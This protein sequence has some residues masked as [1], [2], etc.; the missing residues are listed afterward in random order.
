MSNVIHIGEDGKDFDR[1]V[2]PD[3]CRVKC[4]MHTECGGFTYHHLRQLCRYKHHQPGKYDTSIQSKFVSCYVYKQPIPDDDDAIGVKPITAEEVEEALG[5]GFLAIFVIVAVLIVLAGAAATVL[6]VIKRRQ[7]VT[8]EV[9][10][11]RGLLVTD[12]DGPPAQTV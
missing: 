11:V 5:F 3:D 9:V 6:L 12:D 10:V 2:T 7:R 1:G 8:E 4:G